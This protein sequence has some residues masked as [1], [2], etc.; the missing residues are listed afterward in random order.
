MGP[1]SLA[2]AFLRPGVTARPLL[3]VEPAEMSLVWREGETA[4]VVLGVIETAQRFV[5]AQIA[6]PDAAIGLARPESGPAAGLRRR[7]RSAA[8]NG[9]SGAG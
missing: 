9:A 7:A 5:A 1:E 2:R 6:R 4:P 3:G 8:S